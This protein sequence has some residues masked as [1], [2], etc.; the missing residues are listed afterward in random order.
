MVRGFLLVLVAGSFVAGA[1]FAQGGGGTDTPAPV[2]T[3]A[4]PDPTTAAPMSPKEARRLHVRT[5]AATRRART[6]A[7]PKH[8]G[9]NG[10]GGAGGG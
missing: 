8:G 5:P 6:R 4:T 3:P 2:Q 10:G 7:A 1:A 9:G